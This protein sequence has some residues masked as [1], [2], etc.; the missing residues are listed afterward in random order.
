[1]SNFDIWF[2]VVEWPDGSFG[3]E[4]NTE[5]SHFASKELCETSIKEYLEGAFETDF[6]TIEAAFK[7]AVLRGFKVWYTKAQVR[8]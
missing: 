5:V 1:M 3:D 2:S 7:E 4:Q 6:E 8:S